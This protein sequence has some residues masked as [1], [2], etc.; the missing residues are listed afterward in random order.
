MKKNNIFSLSIGIGK[1]IFKKHYGHRFPYMEI[2]E[3][4]VITEPVLTSL[5]IYSILVKLMYIPLMINIIDW[6]CMMERLLEF[7]MERFSITC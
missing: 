6:F 4:D 7:P 3:I 1:I 2:L 5:N